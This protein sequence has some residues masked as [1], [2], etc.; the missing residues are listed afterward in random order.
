MLNRVMTKDNIGLAALLQTTE[1]FY[2]EGQGEGQL[3]LVATCHMHW[4]PEYCDV[5]L[6]QTMMLIHELRA[7]IRQLQRDYRLHGN[8]TPAGCHD[9]EFVDCNALPLILCGDL[10]S[11]P[12][13]GLWLIIEIIITRIL[14]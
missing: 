6:I 5:K 12:E 3:L 10:N 4:D 8:S 7:L 1:A 14:M 2:T 11:L 9:D 13:S